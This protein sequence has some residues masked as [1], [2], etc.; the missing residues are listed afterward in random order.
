M[1]DCTIG[2]TESRGTN[3]LTTYEAYKTIDQIASLSPREVIMTGGDPLERGDVNQIVN[4]QRFRRSCRSDRRSTSAVVAAAPQRFDVVIRVT[5]EEAV[6]H[7][8][9]LVKVNRP[10][11]SAPTAIASSSPRASGS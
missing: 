9:A 3:E 4:C 8:R 6:I 2:A 7:H 10:Q 1:W 5:T 11:R